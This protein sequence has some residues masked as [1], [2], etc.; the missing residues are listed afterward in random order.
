MEWV[1]EK[2]KGEDILYLCQSIVL[3][4]SSYKNDIKIHNKCEIWCLT[5]ISS[6]KLYDI[7]GEKFSDY[8]LFPVCD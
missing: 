4:V 8:F 3:I 6:I 5:K 2:Q 7:L 1:D